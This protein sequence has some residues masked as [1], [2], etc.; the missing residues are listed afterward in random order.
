M[1][2]AHGQVERK[3]YIYFRI[4]FQYQ[5]LFFATMTQAN[6]DFGY[7]DIDTHQR[8]YLLVAKRNVKHIHFVLDCCV[9][10][11]DHVKIV[12]QQ[13]RRWC[14]ALY[15]FRSSRYI[16]IWVWTQAVLDSHIVGLFFF[17]GKTSNGPSNR[18]THGEQNKII[19]VHMVTKKNA[20]DVTT[21]AFFHV[22]IAN[23]YS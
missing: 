22:F 18:Q 3:N 4:R 16:K 11:S 20:V 7:V 5:R 14:I 15:C 17:E 1:R 21:S 12:A 2:N 23:I 8:H 13:L 6:S 19:V 10:V 9:C